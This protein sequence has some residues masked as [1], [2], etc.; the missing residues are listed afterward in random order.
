[1]KRTIATFLVL[2]FVLSGT[3]VSFSEESN[4]DNVIAS[5]SDPQRNS[6][7]VLNYIA[8]LTKEIEGQKGNRLYLE[9]AY[10]S[11]Y[12]NTYMNSIDEITLGQV[13][14]LLTAL[15]N[16]K[17]LAVKRERLEYIYEQNQAQAVRNSVS[18]PL[19]VLNI[20][21]SRDWKQTLISIVYTA[22]DSLS[23]YESSK[24]AADLEYLKN[25]WE[26]DDEETDILHKGHIDSYEYMWEII[27]NYDLPNDLALNEMDIDRFVSWSN[28]DNLI[29][30]IQFLESNQSVYQ[31]FGEYWLTL[32]ECYY[33]NGNM[34]KCLDAVKA[35]ETYGTR[36]FRKDNHY[37]KV[38]P[39]AIDAASEIYD[40][41]LYISEASRFASRIIN[42]CDQ[43]S[44]LLRYFAAETY[45]ELADRTSDSEY[46]RKAYEEI[47][48][49]NVNTLA[50]EQEQAN[51]VY[52]EEVK[53]EEI[54]DG[55]SEEKK[56]EIEAY[57]SGLLE[58][59]KT[60]LPPISDAL[61]LN[62]DLLFVLADK[63]G[64]D[65]DEVITLKGV[66]TADN[67]PLFLNPLIEQL[68]DYEKRIAISA[69]DINNLSFDGKKIKIPAYYL[70][71]NAKLSVGGL[72]PNGKLFSI[73]NWTI[74]EVERKDTS[75]LESFVATFTSKD[76]E[77][78]KYSAGST[79]WI[80]IS[81]TG[82]DH[83]LTVQI[84]FSV[85][86]K[87]SFVVVPHLVFERNDK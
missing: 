25:G 20:V 35:Y 18:S 46:L 84:P 31:A 37:A 76:A 21:Q 79:V 82:D 66:L 73:N 57:N 47:V 63:L 7:G 86:E 75:E 70:S 74:Q 39:M 1:M 60:A 40:N 67:G 32:A 49:P 62:C 34:E 43:E 16:F 23:R 48:L 54:P 4:N 71:E 6:I 12:N 36:I 42:N 52:M 19:T 38:L 11:L 8:Y 41:D 15:N 51:K 59:R 77:K 27:H 17:M 5:L 58:S 65:E 33:N 45:I 26:L 64:I 28:Y 81:L 69:K 24:N 53:T 83:F 13:K 80:N 29:A 50:R 14:S 68:Y 22:I 55:L 87:N 85:K 3:L 2:L 61:L 72:D 10:S 9:N 30:K 44:W 78:F 56:K